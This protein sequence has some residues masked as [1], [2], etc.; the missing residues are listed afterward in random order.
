MQIPSPARDQRHDELRGLCGGAVFLPGDPGYDDA[1]IPWNLLVDAHP[2]AVVYP[3]FPEEVSEVLRAAA[4]LGL[5]VAPQGTGHG[6]LSLDS[7]LRD[8]VLLRTSAMTE[9]TIDRERRSAWV[10]AG[11][12][13]GDVIRRA[14][15]VGLAGLHM[16]SRDVGVVGSS[17]GGGISWYSRRLGLQSGTVTEVEVV[18]ADG[19]IVR[20]TDDEHADLLW[21]ARGGGGGFGVV[22]GMAF[23]L[24]EVETVYAGMLVWDIDHAEVA[25]RTWARWATDAPE[26]VTSIAR[27][28]NVPDV[29]EV[30][31]VLR[32]RQVV[33]I[34]I[35][36]M[37]DGAGGATLIE[38]LRAID[39]QMD[40]M[41]VVPAASVATLH[42]EPDDPSPAYANSVL[43]DELSDEAI[44][45]I[46]RTAG[47]ASGSRLTTTEIRQLG[48]AIG[49]PSSRPG[50]LD[51]VDGR[52]LLLGLGLDPDPSLWPAQRA[53]S[54]KLLAALR[55]WAHRSVYLPMTEDEVD[56]E[57][58]WAPSSWE[59]LRA[60]RAAA[61][62]NGLFVLPHE[63]VRTSASR[64][65]RGRQ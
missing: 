46:L 17:L 7:D 4:Q 24:F 52:F 30:P 32:G 14:G 39:P 62:P 42:L 10:G 12:R 59:R 56:V 15:A 19:T 43:L 57:R 27:L 63:P 25:L 49:R 34:G 58:G 61:D 26:E 44:D 22:T 1:R 64:A 2:A 11:V 8:A 41:D 3:A 60:I 50:A 65:S 20:A 33:V 16:S 36:V 38:P 54:L 53:D 35:V 13:W 29:P 37:S 21:A 18:L 6:A 51:R 48:G 28:F 40:T 45:V 5:R 47:P 9:L 23:D 31:E 55:P